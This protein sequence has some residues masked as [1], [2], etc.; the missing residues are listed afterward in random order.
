MRKVIALVALVAVSVFTGQAGAALSASAT[1]SS[2]QLGPNSWQYSLTLQNTGTTPIGTYW[3]GWVPLYDL[4]PSMP[5]NVNS[6]NGWSGTAAADYFGVG[7]AQ[8]VNTASPLQPGQSMSGFQ[9]TSPDSPSAINGTSF[10]A[11]FPVEQSYVYIG[12]PET[13]SGF[14]FRTN[15][16]AAPE[17]ASL[18]SAGLAGLLVLIRRKR[19]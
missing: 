5:T 16:V 10:Y 4:L 9:F 11:G 7:S 1:L 8:W 19:S 2:Q 13:D 3:F 12:G 6:P 18:A 14:A 17:P 15:T